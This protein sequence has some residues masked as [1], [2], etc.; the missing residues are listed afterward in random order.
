M[1]K[2]NRHRAHNHPPKGAVV[3]YQSSKE[4]QF[5][6][7]WLPPRGSAA[8]FAMESDGDFK[9]RHPIGYV[10]L[11]ILGIAAFI[12]PIIVFGVLCYFKNPNAGGWISL[13]GVFGGMIAGVGLF[14]LVAVIIKQYLGHLV[15]ILSLLIG[16]GMML[17]CYLAL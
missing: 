17:A 16:G 11:V 4:S 13:L 2:K 1:S 9:R 10:F 5:V 7:Q 14:N 8:Y 3:L 6:H 15:T 12:L